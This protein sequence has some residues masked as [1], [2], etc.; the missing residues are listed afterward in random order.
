MVLNSSDDGS[1]A[2]LNSTRIQR[3]GE[4]SVERFL[5]A[6]LGAQVLG[7]DG[8]RRP[9]ERGHALV[10]SMRLIQP[11]GIVD[12]LLRALA[13]ERQLPALDQRHVRCHFQRFT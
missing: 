13:A 3:E 1:K 6:H 10:L 11:T 9:Q 4:G 8:V 12:H 2:K 5:G 7:R